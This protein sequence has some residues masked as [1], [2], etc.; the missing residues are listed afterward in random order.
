M[1]LPNIDV[2]IKKLVQTYETRNP[3]KLANR[4]GIIIFEEE[5]GEIMGYYNRFKKIKM[6]HVNSSLSEQDKIITCAHEL[7]HSLLHP[8]ENTPMLSQQTIVSELKIE[9]EANYFATKLIIDG[10]HSSFG[11]SCKYEILKYYG[12]PNNFERFL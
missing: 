8:N 2:K 5:L 1:N 9:K 7:G 10:S 11:L 4:L 12:L 3:Y 6:I